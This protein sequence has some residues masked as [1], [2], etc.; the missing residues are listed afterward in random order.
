MGIARRLLES[1]DF[2][3]LEP[4]PEALTGEPRE[5]AGH[6]VAAVAEDRSTLLAYTPLGAPLEVELAR[7]RGD[8]VRAWWFDPR[9]GNAQEIGVVAGGEVR[10]FDPPGTEERG[11]D[12]LLIVDALD[13]GFAG[14]PGSP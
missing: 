1:R 4:T 6:Q 5:G 10:S 7:V 11:N 14:A 3:R 2:F 12:W 13:A 8:R 9:N